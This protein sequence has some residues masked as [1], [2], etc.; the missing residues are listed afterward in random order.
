MAHRLVPGP[1]HGRLRVSRRAEQGLTA[2]EYALVAAVVAVLLAGGVYYLY[3]GVQARFV[4][5]ER[6]ATSAWEGARATC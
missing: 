1:P 2:I 3:S 5:D 6:C 4:R